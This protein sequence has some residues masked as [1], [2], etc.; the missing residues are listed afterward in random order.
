MGALCAA[1]ILPA[2]MVMAQGKPSYKGITKV[3]AFTHMRGPITHPKNPSFELL[4]YQLNATRAFDEAM[5][6]MVPA[7][8]SKTERVAWG[9]NYVAT[10]PEFADKWT[11]AMVSA[12]NGLPIYQRYK[13][14][15]RVPAIVINE[16]WVLTGETDVDKAIAL[17]QKQ[18][19]N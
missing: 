7:G 2:S 3:E 6:S 18:G 1:L 16:T 19:R 5:D 10:H 12:V 4:I 14:R 8:L 15:G 11:K 13:T 17:Y 9:E